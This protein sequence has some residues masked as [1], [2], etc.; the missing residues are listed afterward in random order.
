MVMFPFGPRS[1]EGD[2]AAGAGAEEPAPN[3]GRAAVTGPL[4]SPPAPPPPGADA[5][6]P[7][8]PSWS[9]RCPGAPSLPPAACAEVL[10]S[11]AAAAQG[12]S[13]P[14]SPPRRRPGPDCRVGS[15]GQHGLCASLGGPGARLF[16][17]LRARSLGRGLCVDPARDNFRTMTNLYGSIHPADSV[18]LSTRT[19]GAVFNLEYSPDG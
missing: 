2:E 8:S 13:S 4:P 14:P 9:P 12:K 15:R 7:P 5:V 10:E 6:P 17:W 18:Y 19:H 1:P 11:S 3:G 16:G